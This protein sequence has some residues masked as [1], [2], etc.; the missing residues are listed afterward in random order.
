M[1]TLLLSLVGIAALLIEVE[2]MIP[3]VAC[4][5]L[6]GASG[7]RIKLLR[8]EASC[9]VQLAPGEIATG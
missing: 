9:N 8:E 3:E 2:V 7:D 4:R 1:L 5:H 6:V